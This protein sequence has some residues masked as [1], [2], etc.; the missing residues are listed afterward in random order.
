MA[1]PVIRNETKVVLST[2]DKQFKKGWKS[3]P[4]K[5]RFEEEGEQP[6]YL[7]GTKAS[8]MQRHGRSFKEEEF[9]SPVKEEEE[10]T[11]A[12]APKCI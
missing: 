4:R 11:W 10:K 9:K 5:V 7:T 3:S 1:Q 8:Q 2:E 6:H 12:G